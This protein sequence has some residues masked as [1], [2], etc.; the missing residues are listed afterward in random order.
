MA[1]A[2]VMPHVWTRVEPVSLK[3]ARILRRAGVRVKEIPRPR[4]G[5]SGRPC[6]KSWAAVFMSQ[7]E[8]RAARKGVDVS[9]SEGE[10]V[11]QAAVRG[12]ID[13]AE[14]RRNATGT[15]EA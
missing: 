8:T 11:I 12:I 7:E 9:Y 10:M 2:G 3:S 4:L 13:R 14:S 6:R 5:M 1:Q 15:F